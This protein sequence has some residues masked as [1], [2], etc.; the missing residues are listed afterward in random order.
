MRKEREQQREQ[1]LEKNSF[2]YVTTTN[3]NF[4]MVIIGRKKGR[5]IEERKIRKTKIET[6]KEGREER[7]T[8][9]YYYS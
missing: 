7:T 3:I 9:S 2:N 8:R 6:K 5:A 4:R 1:D